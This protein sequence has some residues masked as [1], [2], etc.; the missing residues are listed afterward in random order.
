[1]KYIKTEDQP[2]D[3]FTKGLSKSKFEDFRQQLGMTEKAKV[4]VEG[5]Y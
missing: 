2:A 1:M 3:I 4:G 5:E